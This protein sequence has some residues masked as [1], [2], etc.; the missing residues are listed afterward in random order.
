MARIL[1]HD[2]TEEHL[3]DEIRVAPVRALIGR[4]LPTIHTMCEETRRD[5]LRRSILAT[6][7]GGGGNVSPRRAG[8]AWSDGVGRSR[9]CAPVE[10]AV[11]QEAAQGGPGPELE[12][13]IGP[14]GDRLGVGAPIGRRF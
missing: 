3:G 2:E 9:A 1:S 12:H 10:V 8:V 7:D 11:V 4:Q 13:A 6:A 5:E 14:S